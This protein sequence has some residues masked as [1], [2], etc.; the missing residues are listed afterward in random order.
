MSDSNKEPKKARES[1]S[2]PDRVDSGDSDPVFAWVKEHLA[3]LGITMGLLLSLPALM[4]ELG[5]V[6]PTLA[7]CSAIVLAAKLIGRSMRQ[8]TSAK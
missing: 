8:G 1:D 5:F 4:R 6:G 2:D 3:E 7:I